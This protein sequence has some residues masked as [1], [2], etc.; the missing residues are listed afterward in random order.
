[1]ERST[2]CAGIPHLQTQRIEG[3]G[4][5]RI[6]VRLDGAEIKIETLPALK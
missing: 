1:M 3:G 2:V 5:T 4:A 6:R